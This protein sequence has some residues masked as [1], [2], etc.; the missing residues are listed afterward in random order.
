M[1]HQNFLSETCNEFIQMIIIGIIG[2]L[3]VLVWFYMFIIFIYKSNEI[4]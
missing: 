2:F 1:C 3:N 4:E